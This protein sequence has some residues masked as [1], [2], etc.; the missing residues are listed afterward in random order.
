MRLFENRTAEVDGSI[1]FGSTIKVFD[2][3]GWLCE[4]PL[5]LKAA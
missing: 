4:R 5:T 2:L 1:P 3:A